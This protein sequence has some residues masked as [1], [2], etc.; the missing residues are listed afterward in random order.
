MCSSLISSDF[1]AFLYPHCSW[2]ILLAWRLTSQD[3]IAE[4][5]T[6]CGPVRWHFP[7][8]LDQNAI[9]NGMNNGTAYAN[10]D[11]GME[12]QWKTLARQKADMGLHSHPIVLRRSTT[13]GSERSRQ[14]NVSGKMKEMPHE[15]KGKH[16]EINIGKQ[17]MWAWIRWKSL[18]LNKESRW[19][20]AWNYCV[21]Q[22]KVNRR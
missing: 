7:I 2:G 4:K 3:R 12:I 14:K 15:T 21:E 6:R 16:R 18:R 9:L 5:T 1:V 22:K 13:K 8:N 10:P 11:L 17:R 20:K 19:E